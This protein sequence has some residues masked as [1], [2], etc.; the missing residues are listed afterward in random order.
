MVLET[1]NQLTEW[2]LS[3]LC[4]GLFVRIPQCSGEDLVEHP[5]LTMKV[6]DVARNLLLHPIL[7]SEI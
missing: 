5:S 6:S 4:Y 2:I 3:H 1:K 7:W